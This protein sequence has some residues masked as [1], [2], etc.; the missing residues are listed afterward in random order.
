MTARGQVRTL[1][2]LNAKIEAARAA[3]A[4]LPSGEVDLVLLAKLRNE[5]RIAKEAAR[6]FI[7]ERK[8]VSLNGRLVR[9]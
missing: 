7:F 5:L 9:L 2:S 8:N 4:A 3:I 6:I 1:H